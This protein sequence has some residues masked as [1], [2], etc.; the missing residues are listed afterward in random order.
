MLPYHSHHI[1][2]IDKF[3]FGKS[4]AA[5]YLTLIISKTG[6]QPLLR[7]VSRALCETRQLMEDV[8]ACHLLTDELKT[9]SFSKLLEMIDDKIRI[10]ALQ[11]PT[12]KTGDW[13][14]PENEIIRHLVTNILIGELKVLK[15]RAMKARQLQHNVTRKTPQGERVEML[16]ATPLLSENGRN[17]RRIAK[18]AA[19]LSRK[20]KLNT[21]YKET[22]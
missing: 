2:R 22:T 15:N 8:V 11:L 5:M 7:K 12:I 4:P 3:T 1:L 14:L 21:L 10:T 6:S 18:S 13:P 17:A 19:Y 20:G 16:K 9:R